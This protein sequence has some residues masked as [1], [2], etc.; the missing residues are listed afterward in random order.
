M[1]KRVL[2]WLKRPQG[3]LRLG[4]VLLMLGA[5]GAFIQV[6]G[7]LRP[8]RYDLCVPLDDWLP[9]QFEP[10]TSYVSEDGSQVWIIYQT[11]NQ[12][13]GPMQ[14]NQRLM[15]FGAVQHFAAFIGHGIVESNNTQVAHIHGRSPLLMSQDRNAQR[16]APEKF[17][18]AYR[19]KK[20]L[21]TRGDAAQNHPLLSP[22]S[23]VS[24]C[25]A[26]VP[27]RIR[28]CPETGRYGPE[29]LQMRIK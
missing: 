2:G 5:V 29:E 16:R 25:T 21:N 28:L 8:Q 27:P 18:P 7:R 10:W 23:K 14:V 17:R 3:F 15:A 11:R 6:F 12:E 19:K 22:G 24:A 9:K 4:A 1:I 13:T 20:G 26:T